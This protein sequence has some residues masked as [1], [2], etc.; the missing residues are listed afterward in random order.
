MERTFDIGAVIGQTFSTLFR[1]FVPFMII[2]GLVLTPTLAVNLYMTYQLQAGTFNFVL[3]FVQAALSLLVF[4]ATGAISYGVFQQLRHKPA[5]IGECLLVGL[6]RMF[7]VMGVA[8]LIVL[9][10]IGGSILLII[11]GII[12]YVILYVAVPA[13]VV[14]R[15]GVL[16][17][18]QRSVELT[19][20]FRWRVFAVI[21]VLWLINMVISMPVGVVFV[22]SP[23]SLASVAVQW[24]VQVFGAALQAT[25]MA[26]S[27][28]QLRSVKEHFDVEEI[29]AVFA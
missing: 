23:M 27:Y 8:L 2:C 7:P 29:A 1:N 24:I 21:F 20:D 5:S 12:A 6:K 11:P 15:P 18:L 3:W 17:A 9:I 16:G 22:F 13:A 10:V 28:Y 25:A 26:L 4:V 14:E 19:R